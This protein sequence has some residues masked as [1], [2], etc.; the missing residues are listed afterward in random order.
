MIERAKR[1]KKDRERDE[2]KRTGVSMGVWEGGLFI[3]QGRTIKPQQNFRWSFGVVRGCKTRTRAAADNSGCGHMLFR[4]QSTCHSKNRTNLVYRF[5]T[6]PTF[7]PSFLLLPAC[8]LPR[9][10][11]PL[12]QL[13]SS[14]P[15]PCAAQMVPS[16]AVHSLRL[17]CQDAASQ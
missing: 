15:F 16:C 10:P 14:W 4:I 2:I 11:P 3:W 8:Y 5:G 7:F 17:P 1:G 12:P 6:L 9:T 13:A